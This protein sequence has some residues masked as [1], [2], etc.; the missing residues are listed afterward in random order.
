[1]FGLPNQPKTL[2]NIP[3]EQFQNMLDYL[4]IDPKMEE[5]LTLLGAFQGR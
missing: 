1:M 3:L 2:V 5:P 4:H